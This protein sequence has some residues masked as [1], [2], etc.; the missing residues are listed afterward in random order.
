MTHTHRRTCR[1]PHTQ[2]LQQTDSYSTFLILHTH[3]QTDLPN[4]THS[5]SSRLT[6]TRHS[7]YDTHTD[8][9][10][11]HHILN[12]SSRPTATRHSSY[13]THRDRPTCPTPHTHCLADRQLIGIPRVTRTN[14]QTCPTHSLSPADRQLIGIPR[15]THAQTDGPAQH[16]AHSLQQTDGYR[17]SSYDTHT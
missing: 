8:G 15:M 17:R 10:V 16:H 6:A 5:L 7:S 4:T 14:R 2:S 3:K 12:L 13:N 11:Q 9:P 1:T